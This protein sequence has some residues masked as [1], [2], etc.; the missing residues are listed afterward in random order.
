MEIE[1]VVN[2]VR[3]ALTV[4]RVFGEPYEKDGVTIIPAA[5]VR[6]GAGGGSAPAEGAPGEAKGS[7]TGFG[8]NARPVGIYVIRGETVKYRPAIDLNRIIAGAQIVAA[9][10]FITVRTIARARSRMMRRALR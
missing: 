1:E 6:G 4:K 8:I 10:A 2:G 5:V 9:I 7:G 3:D